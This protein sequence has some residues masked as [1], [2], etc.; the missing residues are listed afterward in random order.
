M[1]NSFY[2]PSGNPATGS[3]GSSAVMRTELGLIQAAFDKM[4]ALTANTA[5]VVNGAG[6][7]LTNTVGALALAGNFTTTGAW[8]TTL[9]AVASVSITLPGIAATLATLTGTETLTNK[10]LT[11]P[12]LQ[13]PTLGVPASGTLTLCTGLPIST[14]VAGLGTGV[15]TFL[16][17]ASS[18]NLAAALTDEVGTGK[19][20]FNNNPPLIGTATNDDAVAGNYGEYIT[21][22]ATGVSLVSQTAKTLTSIA[23]T[24]GDWDIRT[25][26][27][28]GGNAATIVDGMLTSISLVNNTFDSTLGRY[29][30]NSFG[31]SFAPFAVDV[32]QVG[33]SLGPVRFSL[34]G[35]TTI[36]SIGYLG[37]TVSTATSSAILSARR[38]R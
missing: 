33:Q 6:T 36:Y 38:V 7:A 1:S 14:G 19:A 30:S 2:T 27:Q 3:A 20:V 31:T 37:F 29:I 23:L 21:A 15:A 10:T 24:A 5:V 11:S 17:T 35:N 32:G 25:E 9:V 13:T 4:P 28:Y 34:S 8:N 18:A 16:A 22:S 26:Q 12:L